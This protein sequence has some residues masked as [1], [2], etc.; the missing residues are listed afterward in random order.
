M[1]NNQF[2]IS[3]GDQ[4]RVIYA[5]ILN[6]TNTVT[7]VTSMANTHTNRCLVAEKEASELKANRSCAVHTY[8]IKNPKYKTIHKCV[9]YN[10]M[11]TQDRL[12]FMDNLVKVLVTRRFP[13]LTKLQTFE[14]V[15]AKTKDAWS[16]STRRLKENPRAVVSLRSK[17]YYKKKKRMVERSHGSS[18]SQHTPGSN[19]PCS[20]KQRTILQIPVPRTYVNMMNIKKRKSVLE[21][22]QKRN[23]VGLQRKAS[24]NQSRPVTR[25]ITRS[26]VQSASKPSIV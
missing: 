19:A 10:F 23:S 17:I 12:T 15:R 6:E 2:V 26:N 11:N 18:Q 4:K 8:K 3:I 24:K 25:S 13:N 16:V 20:S 21:L 22:K 5:K 9:V 1:N 7:C 14:F